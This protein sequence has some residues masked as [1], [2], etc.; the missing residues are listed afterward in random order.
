MHADGNSCT[1]ALWAAA[2]G[3]GCGDGGCRA[4]ERCRGAGVVVHPRAAG[5]R[6]TPAY[7]WVPTQGLLGNVVAAAAVG[8]K[9][10]GGAGEAVSPVL[11]PS[12]RGSIVGA[13]EG[14]VAAG[15]SASRAETADGVAALVEER[16]KL[17]RAV[18]A[19]L[20]RE[21][22]ALRGLASA[23][24]G[25]EELAD[26]ADGRADVAGSESARGEDGAYGD[27]QG[28][29]WLSRWYSVYG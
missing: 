4:C 3:F 9:G 28:G 8:G 29:Q 21:E 10:G 7:G 22:S 17:A 24:N 2:G 23:E 5:R 16:E 1:T 20:Q 27:E 11:S 26:E 6:A 19:R 13:A 14:A 12:A 18:A 25:E 15:Q